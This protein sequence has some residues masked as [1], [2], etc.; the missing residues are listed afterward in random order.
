MNKTSIPLEVERLSTFADDLEAE[1]DRAMV[2]QIL[3][4]KLLIIKFIINIIYLL[5][6]KAEMNIDDSNINYNYFDKSDDD[7]DSEDELV[8]AYI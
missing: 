3:T 7:E 2:R 8:F 4:N 5:Y 1:L 6:K